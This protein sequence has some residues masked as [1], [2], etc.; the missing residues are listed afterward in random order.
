MER[1]TTRHLERFCSALNQSLKRPAK[2]RTQS[3]DIAV[4]HIHLEQQS[5]RYAIVETRCASGS[6][7]RLADGDTARECYNDGHAWFNG[8][9][10][11]DAQK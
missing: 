1:I 5:G 4:G 7:N 6:T 11:R 8:Y 9:L 2:Y 3:G 10:Y